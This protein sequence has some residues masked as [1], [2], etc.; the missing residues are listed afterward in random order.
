MTEDDALQAALRVKRGQAKL[1]DYDAKDRPAIYR[2][3]GRTAKLAYLARSQ[4]VQLHRLDRG[5]RPLS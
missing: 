4:H 2:A 3:L 1:K 5:P